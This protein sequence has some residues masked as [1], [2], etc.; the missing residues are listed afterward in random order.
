MQSIE[1]CAGAGGQA[2][3]LEQA[4][5]S[6]VALVEIDKDACNT[7]KTNRPNWNVINGDVKEFNASQYFGIDL[8]AGGVPCPPFSVAGKQLGMED[9]RDLFPE[10]IRLIGECLPKAV[11]LENVR[12]LLNPKFDTYRQ[13]ITEQITSLGYVCSWKMLNANHFGVPQL[14]PRTLMVALRPEY[15][16]YFKWPEQAQRITLTVGETLYREMASHGWEGAHEWALIANDIA[17]TLVGGSKKHGGADLG[18]TRARLAWKKLGIDG[19][20]LADNP[21]MPGFIGNPKLTVRMASLIQGFPKDWI[22][23]G[24]KTPSYRQVGNAFPPPVAKAVGTEIRK[25]L[26]Q[27]DW[28]NHT[29]SDEYE[30]A[31]GV[32]R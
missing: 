32:T 12:G 29:E 8:F 27:G 30:Q 28:I 9:E 1:I 16:K 19:S 4:G 25:A 18:P 15:V 5:F 3:G 21:P 14:R 7:L 24:K 11:L 2:L 13:H 23:T 17:P 6:H 26:V 20:G 22:F 31:V 10:A